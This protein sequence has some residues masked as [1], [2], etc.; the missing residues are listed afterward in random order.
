MCRTWPSNSPI[1][2]DFSLHFLFKTLQIIQQTAV[3]TRKWSLGARWCFYTCLSFC[4]QGGLICLPHCMLGYTPLWAD[5]P[6]SDTTGYG[7]Q[8][9]GTLC[10][11]FSRLWGICQ[12]ESKTV[13]ATER[14]VQKYY[15]KEQK[16]QH[17][18]ELPWRVRFPLE[19]LTLVV[20]IPLSFLS[21]F[22]AFPGKMVVNWFVIKLCAFIIS[23]NTIHFPNE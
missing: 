2:F 18:H 3:T 12:W 22:P 23:M 20:S 17:T 14:F 13:C 6:H 8:A 4:S 21:L 11:V 5:T 19:V 1:K 7:Q 15:V 9:G 16:N 10:Q